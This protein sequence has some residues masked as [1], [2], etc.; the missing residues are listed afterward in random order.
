M[1]MAKI[2]LRGRVSF[3]HEASPSIVGTK[4]QLK[5][6]KP[7]K[8]NGMFTMRTVDTIDQ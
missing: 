3:E 8:D 5:D 7:P 2:G 6:F 1:I 4:W